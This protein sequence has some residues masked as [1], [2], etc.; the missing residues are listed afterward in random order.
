MGLDVFY[1]LYKGGKLR[2]FER[3]IEHLTGA[4]RCRPENVIALTYLGRTHYFLAEHFGFLDEAGVAQGYLERAIA[5]AGDRPSHVIYG[6][7]GAV[8]LLQG[9]RATALTCYEDAMRMAEGRYRANIHN[10]LG[11]IATVHANQGNFEVALEKY[12]QAWKMQPDDI[13]ILVALTELHL[14]RGET[15]EALEYAALATIRG[16]RSAF[17]AKR[18]LSASA[19][20]AH[21]RTRLARNEYSEAMRAL[22]ELCDYAVF[23]V[24]DFSLAG[25]LLATFPEG[26]LRENVG[27]ADAI[28]Q[29]ARH[30]GESVTVEANWGERVSPIALRASAASAFL[31]GKYESAIA[32]LDQAMKEREAKW[33]EKTREHHWTDDAC[34]RYF[35]AAAH[36]KLARE[37]LDREFHEQ[38]AR[39]Y[40]DEAED[41]YLT[42]EASFQNADVIDRIRARAREVMGEPAVVGTSP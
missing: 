41:L 25:I 36:F 29:L 16:W 19:C 30:L 4:L 10:V 39:A 3:A 1:V 17:T 42:R 24:R 37:S 28:L 23:S 35:L 12:L 18:G 14:R 5:S 22:E 15:D 7:L 20:L 34:D 38:R 6:T 33:P 9:D 31:S 8:H 26:W 40:Y 21:A 13:P 11:G 27:Q 32:D 2:E